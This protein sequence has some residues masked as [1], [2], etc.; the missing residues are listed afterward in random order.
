MVSHGDQAPIAE[1][2]NWITDGP[3]VMIGVGW[4]MVLVV[5]VG[6]AVQTALFILQNGLV[7]DRPPLS[8]AQTLL[9][10]ALL[11]F[12]FTLM[13]VRRRLLERATLAM[14]VVAPASSALFGFGIR[15]P[16]LAAVRLVSHLA[17]YALAALVAWNVLVEMR[18]QVMST[19]TRHS[20]G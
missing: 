5:A 18:Q 7:A 12:A 1:R 14:G 9:R 17:F 6:L 15:S 20:R 8:V 4:L 19:R 3:S 2:S 16:L 11:T 13:F 10:I